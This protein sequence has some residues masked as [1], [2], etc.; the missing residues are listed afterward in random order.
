MLVAR[1]HLATILGYARYADLA[2]ADQMI[3]SAA[4]VQKMLDEVD[5][6]SRPAAQNEY[7]QLLAFAQKQPGLTSSAR[8]TPATGANS[9][10]ARNMIS[11]PRSVRPYFPYEQ[12]QTGILKTAARLFHVSF[13]PVKDAVVWDNS[14]DTFD[15]FDA[16]PGNKGKL[17]G[18]IYLD[19]HPREGKDKWFSCA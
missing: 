3:G 10:G 1:Q 12:V 16:A 9:I 14:V 18:R 6:V 19:M 7:A 11:M 8:P 17:L 15:V 4:N 5:E 2:T 13:K